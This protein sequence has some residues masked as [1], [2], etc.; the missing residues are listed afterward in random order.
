MVFKDFQVVCGDLLVVV[1]GDLLVVVCGDL[2]VVVC[3][4]LL[5]VVCGDLLVVVC[6]DLLVVVCGD[7]L[8]VV[9]GDLLVVVCNGFSMLSSGLRKYLLKSCFG[10]LV[11]KEKVVMENFENLIL[12]IFGG[13]LGVYGW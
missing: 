10:F 5:V 3:G 2:L 11:E 6:G 4:T 8:V 13:F 7:L 12:E 1:C 9:C